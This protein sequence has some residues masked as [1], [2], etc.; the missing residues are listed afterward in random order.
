M[1]TIVEYIR[2]QAEHNIAEAQKA[3]EEMAADVLKSG[4]TSA[5]K[6]A[7][8]AMKKEWRAWAGTIVLRMLDEGKL[9]SEI[10]AYLRDEAQKELSY[11]C[12]GQAQANVTEYILRG[13]GMLYM[14]D[15][16]GTKDVDDPIV[17]RF[18]NNLDQEWTNDAVFEA[19]RNK[20]WYIKSG[21]AGA[22]CRANNGN[23]FKFKQDAEERILSLQTDKAPA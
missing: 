23:G 16:V 10:T 7:E 13:Q 9:P 8:G 5:V 22:N 20:R 21:F 2:R 1:S 15:L 14:A 18:F 3:R 12:P 17:L 4:P 6:W 11:I 19:T